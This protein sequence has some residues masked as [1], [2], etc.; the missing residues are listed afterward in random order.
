MLASRVVGI[1][2]MLLKTLQLSSI[3]QEIQYV[4]TLSFSHTEM[5]GRCLCG[6]GELLFTEC[7]AQQVRVCTLYRDNILYSGRDKAHSQL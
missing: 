5:V 7:W 2:G 4:K 1:M 6:E 3:A